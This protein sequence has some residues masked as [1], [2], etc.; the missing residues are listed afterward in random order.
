[1]T[2]P[3]RNPTINDEWVAAVD[4][5]MCPLCEAGPF[6]TVALHVAKKHGIPGREFRSMLGVSLSRP[7]CSPSHSDV[8]RRRCSPSEY[9]ERL[10]AGRDGETSA[11]ASSRMR[12][13]YQRQTRERDERIVAAFRSGRLILEIA[14]DERIDPRTIRRRLR[15]NG[16]MDDGRS[17]NAKARWHETHERSTKSTTAT[18]PEDQ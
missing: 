1:M 13:E 4:Q 5:G 11:K 14:A 6:T 8:M 10:N 12:S 18:P 15:K 9:K 16:V 17:G 7:I 2:K 3:I